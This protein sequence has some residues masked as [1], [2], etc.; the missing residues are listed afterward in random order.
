MNVS[1]SNIRI[2][3][4]HDQTLK[5]WRSTKTKDFDLVHIDAHIDLVVQRAKPVEKIL[6]EAKN[7]KE[8]IRNLEYSL[9]F[10]YYEKDFDKQTNIGNYV[11]P[12]MAEGIVK[13]FF[14]VVPGGP[15]EFKESKQIIKKI[16]RNLL[17]ESGEKA[18]IR[19]L[20]SKGRKDG[21]I[22]TQFKGR[23][24]IVCTLDTLPVLKQ[25]VLLDI[26]TDFL[27][28]RSLLDAENTKNISKRKPWILPQDFVN[29]LEEKIKHPQVITIAY[30]VNGSYTPIIYKHFGDEI[31]YRIA[32]KRFKER[33]EKNSQAAH[34]FDLFLSTKKREYYKK[35]VKLNPTYRAA[36]NN[37]G[38]AYLS[39]R[40]LSL[41][42][43]EFSKILR[44]DTKNPACL[45]GL[46]EV[47]LSRKDYLKAKHYYL[48]RY[49]D[50]FTTSMR[51]KWHGE[52][53]YI[54]LFAGPGRCLIRDK[55][56]EI[57]GSPLIALNAPYAFAG[58]F[59]V[60]LNGEA[61]DVLLQRCESHPNY[62][63]V[64]F[65]SGDC[66]SVIDDIMDNIPIRS[67][68][69]AFVDPT[70]LHFKF[71]TLEKLAQRRVDLIITFPE[72]SI[73]RNIKKF[74]AEPHSPLDDVIGDSGWRQFNT[75]REMIEYY[76][77][78]LAS[79][80]YQEVKL[81][82]EIAIR[83]TDKNLPLYFLLFASKHRLGHWFW[84]QI[85]RIDHRRQRRFL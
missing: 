18:A 22:T 52:L 71:S 10:A 36:D 74:M 66:N 69:L 39:L 43:Q 40:K 28:T 44:V 14:W 83:S 23:D 62:N 16:L 6:A 47:A 78:K 60:E 29:R 84:E 70:G 59:F 26:D 65:Y 13:N 19:K 61:L 53:Y 54:D 75:G 7:L 76:R 1:G 38:P 85:T 2:M 5:V 15:R 9:S 67:L 4:D 58:Y 72:G 32:P 33:F 63:R 24:I 27:V 37:Y 25:R 12:A 79:L 41:A 50:T 8:V 30:S 80:S 21:I 31:A 55:E 73:K 81:G 46:G 35:A 68:C 51:K 77:R 42:E 64:K 20:S 82:D 48:T 56:E 3:E 34:C 57:D 11:Y 45:Q 49:I 17:K